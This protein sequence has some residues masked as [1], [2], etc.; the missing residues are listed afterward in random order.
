M[1]ENKPIPL[2]L[3]PITKAYLRDLAETGAYG[4][5]R[6]AVMRRFIENGIVAALEARV[7]EKK[8]IRDFG[9]ELGDDDAEDSGN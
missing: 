2:R 5:N 1:A 6:S 9:E 8:N 4:T 7:L 3:R